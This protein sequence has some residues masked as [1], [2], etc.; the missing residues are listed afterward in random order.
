MIH[1]VTGIETH[2]DGTGNVNP[3]INNNWELLNGMINPAF[4]LT[5][6]Q[7]NGVIGND[8]TTVTASAAI[9]TSDDAS[10]GGATILWDD[11]ST[12]VITA[13][14]SSTV[15][16]VSDSKQVVSQP[17]EIYRSSETLKTA[18]ARGLMRRSRFVSADDTKIPVWQDSTKTF[19]FQTQ[20]GYGISA[21]RL[22]FGGG[23]SAGLA[24]SADAVWDDTNKILTLNGRVNATNWEW[25]IA[26]IASGAAITLDFKAGG[27]G[28]INTLSANVT[29]SSSNLAAGRSK[30]VRIVCDGTPRNLTFPAGWIF[31]NSSKPT[32]IAANKTGVLSLTSFGTT[33]AGVVAVWAVEA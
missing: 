16:T 30:T 6:R 5:A 15:V 33:D 2:D 19:V 21:G 10:G 29:F 14:S 26:T 24:S 25:Q 7:D 23:A 1:G 4:G 11:G 9:F 22:L 13:F 27:L 17:F 28:D 8:G 3:I 31:L 32:S 20:P 18:I 12:A